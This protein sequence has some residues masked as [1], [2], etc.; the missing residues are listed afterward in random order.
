MNYELSD[1][2]YTLPEELI[3]QEAIHPHHDARMMVIDRETWEKVDD[4]KFIDLP[5]YMDEDHIIFFNN[6]KVL[7]SRLVLENIEYQKKDWEKNILEKWEIFFL[8]KWE[9]NQFEALIQPGNKF[10]IWALFYAFWVT[11]RVVWISDSWRILEIQGGDVLDI[12]EK[13]GRLPLPPYISYE[14][15]KEDDY[16][17]IFAKEWWSVAAPTASLHFTRELL[18]SLPQEKE[19]VTLHVGLGTF[20]WIKTEDIRDYQI[21]SELISIE[22]VLFTKIAQLKQNGKKIVGVGTTVCRTLESLPFAWKLLDPT[23][24]K[25]FEKHVC[26]YWDS[27]WNT[28]QDKDYI[29]NITLLENWSKISFET[30]IYITPGYHFAVIDD[31]ITNFHLP[32][33]SLLVLV[34]AFLWHTNT[35]KIYQDAIDLRYRFYSFG[36]GMYIR[37]K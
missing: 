9:S 12:L 29:Q 4:A 3:A 37:G 27:L 30:T 16:Q 13:Y 1:Y 17:T 31:L 32:E 19:Y 10:S 21:H 11:F 5:H 2:S 22:T 34:S 14:K 20:Q 15:E 33:S 7:R 23:I 25:S 18:E 28:N 24:K 8:R 26:D 36:D 35:K 6:S